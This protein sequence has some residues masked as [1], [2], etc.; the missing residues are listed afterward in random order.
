MGRWW[1]GDKGEAGRAGSFSLT[2]PLPMAILHDTPGS[3]GIG[4]LAP[5]CFMDVF[6]GEV[7]QARGQV[8]VGE[9]HQ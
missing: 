9:W 6:L 4:A 5:G 1:K 2:L 3:A 7:S 8:R